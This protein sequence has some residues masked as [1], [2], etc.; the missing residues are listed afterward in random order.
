MGQAD[1][2]NSGGLWAALRSA[3]HIPLLLVGVALLVGGIVAAFA[4]APEPSFEPD[5]EQAARL[6]DAEQYDQAIE[7]LNAR[8]FPYLEEGLTPDQRRRFHV[9]LAR[10]L[11]LAQQARGMDLEANHRN[12][13]GEYLEAE[14][15][16][17]T[18]DAAD[19]F[20][21][22]DTFNRLSRTD[23]A[24]ERAERLRDSAPDRWLELTTRVIERLLDGNSEGRE[25]AADLL[26]R[27]AAEPELPLEIRVWIAARQAEMRI[28]QGFYEEAL[29]RLLRQMPRLREATPV[30][31]AELYLLL[32]ESYLRVSPP[33]HAE[34]QENLARAER[35]LGS[36]GDPMLAR[37]NLS[38][39][40]SLISDPDAEPTDFDEARDRLAVVAQRFA[41]TDQFLP[42][43]L[44]IGEVEA[45]QGNWD[46]AV[47][48]YSRLVEEMETAGLV[49]SGS[50]RELPGQAAEP[51]EMGLGGAL[52]AEA[53]TASLLARYRERA[54]VGQWD[55]AERFARLAER[56]WP[57]GKAPAGVVV[58][59]ARANEQLAEEI[60]GDATSGLMPAAIEI[61][62]LDPTTRREAARRL[63]TAG[64]YYR[65]HA[66]KVVLTDNEAFGESLWRSSL[67]FDRAGERA[68][69]I[70][71]LQRFAEAFPGDERQAEA[72]YRLAQAYQARG[73]YERAAT[74]YQ[75]L[76]DDRNDPLNG[77]GVG[78][79]ADASYVPLAQC[80]L[81]DG[82]SEND[83]EA[84]ALL[85]R[86]VGGELGATRSEN[87]RDALVELGRLY[88]QIAEFER[89]I[90]RLEEAVE[91]YP[92]DPGV[93]GLRFLLADSYRLS[94]G[95]IGER[96]ITEVMPDTER[97]ALETERGDRLRRSMVLYGRVRDELET[98]DPRRR[99]AAESLD[100]KH[101]YFYLG[102]CAFD[103]GDFAAAI[104]HYDTAR[105]RFPADP[106]SLVALVQIVNAYVELG[107][108]ERA[109]TADERAR[110]FFQSLPEAA[111]DDPNLPMTRRDWERWLDSSAQLY[112]LEGSG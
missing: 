8:V 50:V 13:L 110:R 95:E 4:T 45:I 89:A 96:L 80:F 31:L 52:D 92:D 111:L 82:N 28:A 69:A 55:Q 30:E 98:R 41:A 54:G 17:A 91:R 90:E 64:A 3:W 102:D 65:E 20:Y 94:A 81:L 35:V 33:Q 21:L 78:P 32:G 15:R 84:E 10:S 6:I 93:D 61:A 2:S 26:T 51:V 62:A 29:D 9:L 77:K 88:Y 104:G 101:S 105:E 74:E 75:Q 71:T 38:W 12:V 23:D 34:A 57:I 112:A 97:R 16:N 44:A 19:A 66:D 25:A 67:A 43:L 5:L 53:A 103:L 22:G 58:A 100:L 68:V 18:L 47:D 63:R 60:V 83:G 11:Y 70:L 85:R 46:Q 49:A 56:L 108:M 7:R 79:F 1:D 86:V 87:F 106:S 42:A 48:A 40:R 99:T 14:R 39:A 27:L 107:D 72:R 36:G 76:L 73:E 59:V 37:V 109:R 24:I